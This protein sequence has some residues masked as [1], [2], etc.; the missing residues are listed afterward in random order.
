MTLAEAKKLVR[1]YGCTLRETL[2]EKVG[3]YRVNLLGGSEDTAYYTND[4][5]DA[6][7]TARLM[8]ETRLV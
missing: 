2:R 3:E 1:V 7:E 5:D 8:N 4:L 6:V